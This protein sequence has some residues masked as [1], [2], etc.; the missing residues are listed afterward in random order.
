MPA[1]HIRNVDDE[2]IE[3]LKRIAEE[4]HRSLEGELRALLERAALGKRGPSSRGRRKLRLATVAVGSKSA[5]GRDKVY[6]DEE[7]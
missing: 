3:A 5:F 2:V 6:A 4:N 1:L 7:R